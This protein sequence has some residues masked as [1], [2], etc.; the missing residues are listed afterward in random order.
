MP[1]ERA[2]NASLQL[3]RDFGDP[4]SPCA[5]WGDFFLIVVTSVTLYLP[6][7]LLANAISSVSRVGVGRPAEPTSHA[8]CHLPDP[9]AKTDGL[10]AN[11]RNDLFLVFYERGNALGRGSLLAVML[12]GQ[13]G[14]RRRVKVASGPASPCSAA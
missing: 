12:Q 14:R 1:I 10:L 6:Y 4:E 2:D 11:N 3:H 5:K 7:F 13:R 8:P 9:I